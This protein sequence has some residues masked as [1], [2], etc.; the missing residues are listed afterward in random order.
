[1]K[2]ILISI[3]LTCAVLS[4]I[5]A[6][7]ASIATWKNDA[8]GCYNIIHDDYGDRA[9]DGIWK[10]ADTICSNRGIVFTI[11][12]ITSSCEESRSIN[13]YSSPYDYA[14]NVMMDQ[15]GHEIMNH[16]H[17]HSCAVGRAGWGENWGSNASSPDFET[18][19]STSTTSI[20]DNT[21]HYPRYYIFPY[22]RFTDNA[23]DRLKELGYIGSRTGFTSASY[24]DY[25]EYNVCRN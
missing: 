23:N 4:V 16:S 25:P 2:K 22:D 9:V 10:Y 12:A 6:Q 15:H 5:F 1:M 3:N 7:T 14:K 17:T 11:G 18:E 20:F 19:L 8:T 13:T 24:S 21:G